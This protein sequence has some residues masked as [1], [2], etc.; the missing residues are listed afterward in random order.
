MYVECVESAAYTVQV[1]TAEGS[2]ASLHTNC[3]MKYTFL[4]FD[5]SCTLHL[6]TVHHYYTKYTLN[7][8]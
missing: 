7:L 6:T 3:D 5:P 1:K 8:I 2:V 4:Y